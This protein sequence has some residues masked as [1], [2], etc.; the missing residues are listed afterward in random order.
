MCVVHGQRGWE[1]V[2][3]QSAGVLPSEI[4]VTIRSTMPNAVA[5]QC[6]VLVCSPLRAWTLISS[7]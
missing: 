5:V 6:R 4:L 3:P 1:W 7:I 2:G